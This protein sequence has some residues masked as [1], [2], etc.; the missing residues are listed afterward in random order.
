MI[1][2]SAAYKTQVEENRAEWKA[3]AIVDYTDFNLDNSIV[4]S[5]N[6]DDR[7]SDK[8]Q[9]F[10]GKEEPTFKWFTWEQFSFGE[11]FHLRSESSTSFEKGGLSERLSDPND[12]EFKQQTPKVFGYGSFGFAPTGSYND[13]P[14]FSTNF[15]ARTV[16]NL[17]AVFDSKLQE[18]AEEFDVKVIHASGVHTEVVTGNTTFKWTKVLSSAI[19]NATEVKVIVKKW[20]F[21]NSKA[22]VMEMFTSIQVTYDDDDIY[23]LSILE[24]G[25]P[26]NSTIPIGNASANAC[27][28]SLVNEDNEF[29]NDDPIS[30]LAGNVKKNRRVRLELSLNDLN[31]YIPLGTFYTQ[32][33][34][35]DNPNLQAS[36]SGQD[37]LAIMR[38]F[39][40]KKSQ[41][42]TA[43]ADTVVTYTT[44][45]DFNSFTLDNVD[46]LANEMFLGDASE[47][48]NDTVSGGNSFGFT[49]FSSTTVFIGSL[50]CGTAEK[51]TAF[52]YTPGT[53]V[54]LSF[55]NDTVVPPGTT[56]KW[57]ISYTTVDNFVEFDPDDGYVY[58]PEDISATSQ[59][60]KLKVEF[61]SQ[62]TMI[63]PVVEE[64]AITISQYVSL[65]SL[66][67]KVLDDFDDETLLLDGN[68]EIDQEFGEIQIPNAYIPPLSYRDALKLIAEAGAGRVY[69]TRTGA[70]KLETLK[71]VSTSVK[72]YTSSNYFS[73]VNPVNSGE[74]YNRVTVNTQPLE[75]AASSQEVA[76]LEID[77]A[78]TEVQTI[79]F[80]YNF[81]PV[82]TVTFAGLPGSV[83]I[84]NSTIF[85]WGAIIEITNASGSDQQFTLTV[86]GKP[87]SITGQVVVQLD[88]TDSIRD[89]G[90]IEYSI[91]NSLIQTEEQA[92][93][94]TTLMINSFGSQRR[95]SQID[96]WPDPALEISDSYTVDGNFFLLNKNDIRLSQGNLVHI[97][98]GK[99]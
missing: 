35:I 95:E 12:N 21:P 88:D 15:S 50:F 9:L 63:K 67:S 89:N 68:W 85:T 61:I 14:T 57:F 56:L 48:C 40:Y 24:E 8:E 45:A 91:T 64:I 54:K 77:I 72:T 74:I 53:T 97:I 78:D 2:T 13:Y 30:I 7:L 39:Q 5:V 62:S 69:V 33:W 17:K 20:N 86:N 32:Q 73:N 83:T 87:Y 75:Q 70:V 76:S 3:R 41:F 52:T 23:E 65:F 29:D 18:Y 92:N 51:Q 38:D 44:T 27:S 84:T 79:T 4:A 25:D 37:V 80:E 98:G 99:R 26:E 55:A 96:S 49:P 59:N 36:L 66:A 81:D 31:E 19:L 28:L 47:Y 60:F 6:N 43:P 34:N 58:T 22:K 16:Q 42:I 46:V 94:I 10:D 82:D 11:N 71:E 1:D 90:V 93:Q